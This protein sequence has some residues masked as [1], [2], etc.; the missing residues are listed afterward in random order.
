MIYVLLL[1]ACGTSAK[2]NNLENDS[3]KITAEEAY[4]RMNSGDEIT[5]LDVRTQEEYDTV[6]IPGAILIPNEEIG[7][8]KPDQLPDL[9]AEI[10]VYCRAG[11]RS[12]QA[13]KNWFQRYTTFMIL[14][15]SMIGIMRQK[16]G[17]RG[18]SI[19][20]VVH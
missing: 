3:E 20:D 12:A 2:K 7:D 19:A 16:V 4:D 1:S 17:I 13:P 5:I 11:N 10:L 15:V 14:A 18:N 6:H 8:T 9:D